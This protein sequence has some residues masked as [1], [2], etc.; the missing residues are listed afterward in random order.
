MLPSAVGRFREVLKAG[1]VAAQT[2]GQTDKFDAIA[3]LEKRYS[4]AVARSNID[5]WQINPAIHYNEWNNL[6]SE[7][8]QPVVAAF[9]NLLSLFSCN[10]AACGGLLYVVPE[11]GPQDSLKCPCGATSINLKTKAS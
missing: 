2:W 9:R 4:T 7:D 5:Q 10:Q 6:Q 3:A 11:R 1:K 8:F